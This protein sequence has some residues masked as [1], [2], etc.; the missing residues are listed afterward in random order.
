MAMNAPKKARVARGNETT[1]FI[2]PPE[3]GV[4][5]ES[6]AAMRRTRNDP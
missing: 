2:D 5:G 4:A 1:T 6:V 3:I